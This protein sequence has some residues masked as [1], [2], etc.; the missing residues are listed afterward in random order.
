MKNGKAMAGLFSMLMLAAMATRADERRGIYVDVG[1]G[2][3]KVG[4]GSDTN[5]V[6]DAVE[7]NGFNRAT[8]ALDLSVGW[9]LRQNLYLVGSISG[10]GDRLYHS[11]D[12]LQI[13]TYLTGVG[14]RF[15]PLASMKH[16]QF[17]ADVG[18]A[19]V[20]LQSSDDYYDDTVSNNGSG[21]KLSVAYDFDSTL[22]GP[23]LLVGVDLLSASVEHENITGVSLFAKFVFK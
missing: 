10:F 20:L 7:D 6:L 5:D 17:G 12:Y 15:Y 22:K 23:A 3:G 4:Y 9:A 13:N 2:A 14:I 16:L 18:V 8:A 21:F 1:L 19:K 11:S